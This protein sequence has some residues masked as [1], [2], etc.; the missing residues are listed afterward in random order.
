MKKKD[1]N[2]FRRNVTADGVI[3]KQIRPTAIW[4]YTKTNR[5]IMMGWSWKATIWTTSKIGHACRRF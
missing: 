2:V 4:L 3:E 5:F 1:G